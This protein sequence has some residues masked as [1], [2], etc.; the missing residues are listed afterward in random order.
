[1]H[2]TTCRACLARG[3]A[4]TPTFPAQCSALACAPPFCNL[5]SPPPFPLA[6]AAGR[7]LD[8]IIAYHHGAHFAVEVEVVL[9]EDMTV[10][11]SHDIALTLQHKV[12]GKGDWPTAELEVEAG[13]TWL[14]Q[15]SHNP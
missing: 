14:N 3:A 6:R 10:R 15:S 11:E 5:S 12:G 13:M 9:P 7:Q 1:M 4:C 2:A 8:R